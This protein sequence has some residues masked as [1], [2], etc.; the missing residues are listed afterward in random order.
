MRPG[1]YLPGAP[2]AAMAPSVP[3]EF[4]D[5]Y[6][7]EEECAAQRGKLTCPKVWNW[8]VV[9]PVIKLRSDDSLITAQYCLRPEEPHRGQERGRAEEQPAQPSET[10]ACGLVTRSVR[11]SGAARGGAQHRLGM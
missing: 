5:S 9:L 4:T 11:Q 3:G 6:S 10:C 7:A 2:P 1:L 8:R